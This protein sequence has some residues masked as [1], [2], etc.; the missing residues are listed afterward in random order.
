MSTLPL[1]RTRF[2]SRGNDVF[3]ESH[4]RMGWIVFCCKSVSRETEKWID[5]NEQ[6]NSLKCQS[7]GR[8]KKK[9]SSHSFGESNRT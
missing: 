7:R 5:Y 3:L 1:R 9:V 4:E 2:Y 8:S 6:H